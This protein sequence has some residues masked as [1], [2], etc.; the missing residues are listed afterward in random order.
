MTAV[1]YVRV[2][3][4]KQENSADAQE[5]RIRAQAMLKEW[6]LAEV[7]TDLDEFSGNLNRP[8]AQRV[9]D[10]V[11]AKKID[12]VIITKLDRFTRST[13]DAIDLIEL[14]GK[15][16]VALV[17]ITETLDTASPMGRFFVRMIASIAELE[18]EMIGSRT[19]EGLRNLKEQGFPAG[20]APYGWTAQPRTEE[21]RRLKQRKPMLENP[22]EQAV[23]SLVR[24]MRGRGMDYANIAACLNESGYKTRSGGPWLKQYVGRILK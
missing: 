16:N 22:E 13:R 6:D 18:R 2:S 3:T 1:G 8:G 15:K 17:S 23:I 4:D 19:R 21:E 9:L 11:R 7:V 24:E 5:K 12:A 14:F 10:L 20:K